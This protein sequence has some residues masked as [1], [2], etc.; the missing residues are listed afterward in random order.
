MWKWARP[1]NL[2]VLMTCRTHRREDLR[3]PAATSEYRLRGFDLAGSTAML[4]RH[5]PSASTSEAA[6]F[7]ERTQGIPRVQAYLLESQSEADLGALLDRSRKG[8]GEVFDDVLRAALEEVS[9]PTAARAQIATLFAMI[10]PPQL[11]TLADVLG[12]A[13]DN[14]AA[15]CSALYPGVV[16]ADGVAR[17]PDEDFEHYLR[18]RLSEDEVRAAHGRLADHFLAAEDHDAEA[19]ASVADHLKEAG[20]LGLMLRTA[21]VVLL[22]G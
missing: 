1:D 18:D 7:H 15:I 19:A 21:L 6:V 17:F 8:L 16:V 5:F 12:I 11:Q 22:T 10:R 14:A 2:R 13:V 4:R 9:D 20:R 3:A